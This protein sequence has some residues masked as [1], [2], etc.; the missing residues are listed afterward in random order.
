MERGWGT[1]EGGLLPNRTWGTRVAG[2]PWAKGR[3]D[4]CMRWC[5]SE[6]P[7]RIIELSPGAWRCVAGHRYAATTFS[8]AAPSC[9]SPA[10]CQSS[11]RPAFRPRLCAAAAVRPRRQ[12]TERG[13]G[14]HCR[15]VGPGSRQRILEAA[16]CS[17]R[18]CDG[19]ELAAQQLRRSHRCLPDSW[20]GWLCQDVS[21]HGS[22]RVAA[23]SAGRQAR[24][25]GSQIQ[26]SSSPQRW[27]CLLQRDCAVTKLVSACRCTSWC[28]RRTTA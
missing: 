15:A 16:R 8:Q 3:P 28:P 19:A 7:L 14:R 22:N 6:H 26:Q 13:Q 9:S 21:M 2:E 27:G 20:P 1:A 12:H 18:A 23:A 25:W 5:P 24:P 11:S 10:C 4:C 17:R